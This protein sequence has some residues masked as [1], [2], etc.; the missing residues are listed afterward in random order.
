[1]EF[2]ADLGR[3]L[4]SFMGLLLFTDRI[5]ACLL[6]TEQI[7][8]HFLIFRSSQN[9]WLVG[10]RTATR[11]SLEQRSL[12]RTRGETSLASLEIISAFPVTSPDSILGVSVNSRIPVFSTPSA[13]T[14]E[15]SS[16]TVRPLSR[17]RRLVLGGDDSRLASS[18]FVWRMY[19]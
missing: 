7:L 16:G 1:M 4:V 5:A 13:A 6:R 2:R 18:L 10:E 9:P 11:V 3:E 15:L 12:G 17:F 14:S 8:I 19:I